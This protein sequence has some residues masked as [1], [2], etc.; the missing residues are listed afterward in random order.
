MP[1]PMVFFLFAMCLEF[2]GMDALCRIYGTSF[3]MGRTA[4][5]PL[6]G[7]FN[8]ALWFNFSASMSMRTQTTAMTQE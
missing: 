6:Q 1:K 5:N 3:M 7:D 4:W 8:L 2:T